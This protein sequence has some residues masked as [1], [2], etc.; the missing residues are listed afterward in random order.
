MSSGQVAVWQMNGTAAGAS[1]VLGT[2][3]LDSQFVYCGFGVG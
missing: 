2:P 1:G 3:D